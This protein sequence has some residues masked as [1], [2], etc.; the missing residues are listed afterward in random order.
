MLDTHYFQYGE[1]EIEHL[2]A[3]DPILGAAIDEVGHID[4][5]VIPDMFMALVNSIV[6]QQ[7]STKAQATIW[8][9]MQNQFAPLT[10]E[11]I[12]IISAEDLQTC[13]ISMRKALYIKE[14]AAAVLDGS[15]DLAHLHT[16]TDDEICK[17]LCRIKG[18]G[19]WTAEMLMT[20]SMQR[21]DIMSWDDLAIHRG[22]R[23]IY[24]HRKITPELFAK[25]KRRYSPYATVASL[26]LWAIAGGAC[27]ELVDYAPKTEAR[28]KADA[29]KRRKIHS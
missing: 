24:H 23:M 10:P 17:R 6:G 26:Y 29:K 18:I 7:I 12:G 28:K 20:F 13:G 8:E 19:V 11:N 3:K 1:K 27:A 2:K 4:R 16:M 14:I 15:L 5:V 9:R 22:L 21:M 25:Y